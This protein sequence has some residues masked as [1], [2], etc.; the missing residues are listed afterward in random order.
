[1][2]VENKI[3]LKI[4]CIFLIFLCIFSSFSYASDS[5]YVWSSESKS[6]NT[7]ST[8]SSNVY[9]NEVINSD[10]NS[11]NNSANSSNS[12]A[13][14]SNNSANSSNNNAN[15]SNNSDTVTNSNNTNLDLQCGRSCFNRNELW[16]CFI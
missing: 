6:L 9:N 13:N 5:I 8:T 14:S 2:F 10:V 3:Q 1:M 16:N 15:S 4:V 7:T 11:S 12:S